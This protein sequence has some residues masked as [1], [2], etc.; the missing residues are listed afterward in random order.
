MSQTTEAVTS[1]LR[2]K[3]AYRKGNPLS[4]TEK[5]RVSITRKRATHK[6]V[7]VFIDPRLKE[8]LM[9]MCQQDGITQARI[10]E[11][12]IEHEAQCRNIS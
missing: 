10:I 2:T 12:F 11:K 8:L 3:R 6:E 1:S 4:N 5:Q 7:K 9:S